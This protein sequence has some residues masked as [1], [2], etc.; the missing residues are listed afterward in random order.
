[1]R[2]DSTLE[3]LQSPPALIGFSLLMVWSLIWKGFALYRA[4]SNRSPGWFV[5]LMFVNTLGLLEILY[6]S[7]FSRGRKREL[8]ERLNLPS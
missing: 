1:M 4:G 5:V 7:I 8:N 3:A 6:L 2:N